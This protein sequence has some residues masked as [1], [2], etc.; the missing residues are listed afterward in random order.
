[1]IRERV[2]QSN[3]TSVGGSIGASTPNAG[4][5]A[6]PIIRP[7]DDT[8]RTAPIMDINELAG[9]A[10][11][12]DFKGADA[13]GGL[14]IVS[15]ASDDTRRL[16]ARLPMLVSLP[17][18]ETL[19]AAI[20][21]RY[22][23]DSPCRLLDGDSFRSESIESVFTHGVPPQSSAAYLE[24]LAWERDLRDFRTFLEVTERLRAPDGCPWDRA[25][26]H[27]SLAP[28]LMEETY[29]ALERLDGEQ[30]AALCEE[31]GDI[32]LQIGLHSQIADESGA[33]SIAD[34]VEGLLS[35]LIRRHPHVFGEATADTAS[36]VAA[37]WEVLKSRERGGASL[38]EGVPAAMP[39]LAYAYRVQDR[40]SNA[41]FDWPSIDGLLHQVRMETDG[42]AHAG[43]MAEWEH[44]FGNLLFSL[45]SLARH[46]QVDVE[47]AL[48]SANRRFVSQFRA[49]EEMAREEGGSFAALSPEDQTLL[50]DRA[51]E[52][53]T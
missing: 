53:S 9:L 7:T 35:K 25:Q 21:D 29:E 20:L 6:V 11:K 12:L 23:G 36:E 26:T 51:K 27:R 10:A 19:R 38:L 40:A 45:V 17:V 42:L 52:R 4:N 33:F 2:D 13:A 14:L 28:F 16:D 5:A 37:R 15:G 41:G 34:V 48:R 22:P 18:S 24:P 30:P 3:D 31:L 47:A 32:L 46:R 50:W 49:M 1:M 39:A 8:G 44:E 43:Q